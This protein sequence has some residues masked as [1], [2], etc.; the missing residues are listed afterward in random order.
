MTTREQRMEQFIKSAAQDMKLNLNSKYTDNN[1]YTLLIYF[2][3]PK[4]EVRRHIDVFFPSWIEHFKNA[5]NIEVVNEDDW[6]YFCQFKNNKSNKDC[7]NSE[8]LK[9]YIPMD[10]LHV[11]KGAK[12]LFEYLERQNIEHVSKIGSHSRVDDVVIRVFNKEDA[13]KVQKFVASNDYIKEGLMPTNPFTVSDGLISYGCDGA[14]SY[15]SELCKLL[16]EYLL[17]KKNEDSLD[18][19]NLEEFRQFVGAKIKHYETKQGF[20]ELAAEHKDKIKVLSA[21]NVANLLQKTLDGNTQV[22]DVIQHF[23]NISKPDYR[24]KQVDNIGKTMDSDI[25]Y[26]RKMLFTALYE[27]AKKYNRHQART[28]LL[29]YYRD[30]DSTYFTSTN[31]SRDAIKTLSKNDINYIYEVT[32]PKSSN[33]FMRLDALADYMLDNQYMY[34]KG[35]TE[36]DM[37]V[38]EK[39]DPLE[40]ACVETAK[41]YDGD[42][43]V[44]ALSQVLTDGIYRGFTRNNGVRDSLK[45]S[46]SP[47]QILDTIMQT[48][49]IYTVENMDKLSAL[50]FDYLCT[51]YS[52]KR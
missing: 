14:L 37:S 26:K 44:M 48:L 10:S 13:I 45:N 47:K 15:N 40:I 4:D 16:L 2:G 24:N 3:M 18:N 33:P 30:N 32:M 8:Q 38:T 17:T 29:A 6:S 7:S 22:S 42:F 9:I 20:S 21:Y 35:D 36:A 28:A 1:I 19:A 34:S 49:N 5:K 46:M 41:K 11:E 52:L 43:A 12:I 39:L 23:E 25:A 51:K 27:T 31:G 50:Y